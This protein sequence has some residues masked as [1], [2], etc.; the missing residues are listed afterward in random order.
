MRSSANVAGK[1]IA[2]MDEELELGGGSDL[3][4]NMEEEEP[5]FADDLEDIPPL[6][7]PLPPLSQ[8]NYSQQST[9]SS[10]RLNE[11]F[12]HSEF[13]DRQQIPKE[14]MR[15]WLQMAWHLLLQPNQVETK[16]YLRKRGS[17]Y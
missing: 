12:T 16:T 8:H 4:D 6:P 2:V 5:L 13:M 1:I 7:P 17:Q 15:V 14:V 9:V 3:G 10:S 11:Y